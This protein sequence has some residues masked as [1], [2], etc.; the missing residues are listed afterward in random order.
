MQDKTNKKNFDFKLL[1]SLVQRVVAVVHPI[2]IILFGSAARGEMDANSDIDILVIV[3]DGTQRRRTAQ[4]IYRHLIGF[5]CAVDVIVATESDLH[6]YGDRFGLVYYPALREGKEIY[7][8]EE[9]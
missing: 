7:V 2:K 8:G 5:Q 9:R 4:K 3:P 1:E 6:N